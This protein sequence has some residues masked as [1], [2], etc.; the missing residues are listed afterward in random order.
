MVIIGPYKIFPRLLLFIPFYAYFPNSSFL[1]FTEG[2]SSPVFCIYLFVICILERRVLFCVYFLLKESCFL[3][4]A[5]SVCLGF[6]APQPSVLKTHPCHCV[7]SQ[8]FSYCLSGRHEDCLY[9][10]ATTSNL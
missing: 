5:H 8:H 3:I 1:P 2:N 7:H 9:L 4:L 6:F 10:S